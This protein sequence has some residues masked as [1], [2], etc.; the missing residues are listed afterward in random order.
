MEPMPNLSLNVPACSAFVFASAEQIDGYEDLELITTRSDNGMLR[1]NLGG[2][3]QKGVSNLETSTMLKDVMFEL[4]S[5]LQSE[6]LE[7]TLNFKSWMLTKMYCSNEGIELFAQ[8]ALNKLNI[9][10]KHNTRQKHI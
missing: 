8:R 2:R 3:I 1:Y 9:N 7:K 10:H 5:E 4:P 6:V